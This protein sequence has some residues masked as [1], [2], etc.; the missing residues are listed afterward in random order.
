M[1]GWQSIAG[2][3]AQIGLPALGGL[4]GGPL[5]STL[6]GFAG[7]AVAAALGV[8]PTPQAVAS[9]IQAD[10]SGAAVRLA[11]IEAETKAKEAELAD[12]AN[13]RA[14]Q[15]SLAQSQHWTASMPAIVSLLVFAS[16]IGAG[17]ALFFIQAEIPDRVYQLLSQIYGSLS[18]GVG[19]VLAFWLGSS[20]TSQQ[21]DA[22]IS[23]LTSAA[24]T[25]R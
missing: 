25:K 9:A 2:Q 15:V 22:Q 16:Y 24:I 4:F 7:K 8:E 3:L 10:P 1:D 11:Q 6:G 14:M 20:R 19:T 17:M 21:K 23:A 13:A 18:L 12:I 5:G